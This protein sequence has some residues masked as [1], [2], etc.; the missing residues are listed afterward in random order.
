MSESKVL[1]HLAFQCVNLRCPSDARLFLPHPPVLPECAVT[2]LSEQVLSRMSV[3]AT[4][5]ELL[6]EQLRPF[7]TK[8]VEEF[9]KGAAAA[10]DAEPS[11]APAPPPRKR[12]RPP[13]NTKHNHKTTPKRQ[14]QRRMARLIRQRH[15]DVENTISMNY[16]S[17]Q[18]EQH[19]A[20]IVIPRQLW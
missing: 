20:S 4:S 11:A 5:L 7:V 2:E 12:G 16:G 15:A 10:P 1:C 17:A 3:M 13:K 9:H 18:C 8:E 19:T 6:V 14:I